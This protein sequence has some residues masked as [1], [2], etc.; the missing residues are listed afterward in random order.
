MSSGQDKTVNMSGLWR[1]SICTYD[2]D[3]SALSC[4]M[5]GVFQDS[6]VNLDKNG[7]GCPSKLQRTL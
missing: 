1:C 4:D 6:S 2:D 5:C 7:V 3:G